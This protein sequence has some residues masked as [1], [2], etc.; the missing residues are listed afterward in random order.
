M[1]AST[2]GCGGMGNGEWGRYR[3]GGEDERRSDSEKDR[4]TTSSEMACKVFMA[5]ALLLDHCA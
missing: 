3:D 1:V 5:E 4:N 2:Y